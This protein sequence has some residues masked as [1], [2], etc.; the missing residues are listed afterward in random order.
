MII[1]TGL[2]VSS[3][4][5][6]STGCPHPG[7][8]VSTTVTPFAWTN[9][10]VLPPPAPPSTNRL[11]FSLVTS[12]AAAE[13]ACAGACCAAAAIASPPAT[14]S[15][16]R[17]S[18]RFMCASK[19]N[20]EPA[21]AGPHDRGSWHHVGHRLRSD[22]APTAQRRRTTLRHPSRKEHPFEEPEGAS[23]NHANRPHECQPPSSR[24]AAR[25]Q[26]RE[27][28]CNNNHDKQLPDFDAQVEGEQRP[29]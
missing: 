7:F 18:S 23:R 25:P 13:G 6:V 1:V 27:S 28:R 15:I 14:M 19:K 8:F 24:L 16:P 2:F 26:R 17:M 29:D 10:E 22:V 21:K 11:S 3:R 12:R 9:T 5:F 4:I 20:A